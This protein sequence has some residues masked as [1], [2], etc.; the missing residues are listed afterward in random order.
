MPHIH[1]TN[2]EQF[3]FIWFCFVSFEKKNEHKAKGEEEKKANPTREQGSV[4]VHLCV[5]CT[6]YSTR[7]RMRND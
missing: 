7:D 4:K 6:L 5:H 3:C 2:H 1:R